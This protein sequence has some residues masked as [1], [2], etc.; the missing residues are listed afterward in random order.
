VIAALQNHHSSL[1]LVIRSAQFMGNVG[2]T[3]SYPPARPLDPVR[4][5]T[6]LV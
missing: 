5:L 4:F 2:W 1:A 3:R 6:E